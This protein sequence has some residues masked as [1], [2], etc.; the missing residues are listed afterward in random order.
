MKRALITPLLLAASMALYGQSVPFLNAFSDARIAAMGNAGYA[1]PTVYAT[2]HN[3]A[4]IL[5]AEARMAAAV[6]YVQWQPRTTN[7][8]LVNVAACFTGK[9]IGFAAGFRHHN[10]AAIPQTDAQGQVTGAFTPREYAIDAGMAVKV[11]APLSVAATVR[12]IGSDMG[13][14]EKGSAFAADLSVSYNRNNLHLGLGYTNMGTKMNYGYSEY[15][16]PARLKAGA[17]YR[18]SFKETHHFT[19]SIDAGYQLLFGYSGIV[20]GLGLEYVYK[21]WGALR[22]GYH[23]EDETRTGSSY[24]SIGCG[25]FLFGF[26]LDMAYMLAGSDAP[27]RQTMIISL[28]YFLQ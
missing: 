23:M 25:I 6:S 15:G 22:A 2:Q 1:L 24:A 11:A 4:A 14:P 9:R 17:A 18:L 10:L 16:L 7:S 19:G 12:Y 21:Q 28:G 3:N 20:G 13:G 26:K 8:S 27:M 5:H